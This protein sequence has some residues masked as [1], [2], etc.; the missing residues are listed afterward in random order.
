MLEHFLKYIRN[1]QLFLQTDKVLL[2]VSGGADSRA[3]LHLF[4]TAGIRTAIA[5]CN[6]HL[7]GVESDGDESFVEHLAKEYNLQ[8]FVKHFNTTEYA[9]L[10]KV[11]IQM[12]AREL[13]YNW[14]ENLRRLN[15][16]NYIAT[17]HNADDALETFF[18]NLLRGSGIQGLTGIK[19]RNGYM[20][21]PLLFAYRSEIEEFC[22][23]NRLDFRD[24]SSN[25]S[26]KYLRNRLRHSL[27][28]LL[29]EINP[30]FRPIMTENLTRLS[31][32]E[33]VYSKFISDISKNILESK[34]DGNIYIPIEKLK[35]SPIPKALLFEL[36]KSYGFSSKT[37]I[38]IFE[39][40]DGETGN[41]Y[42]SDEK[43][44]IKD[45]THL[46]ITPLEI[47]KDNKY[48]IDESTEEIMNPI[49]LIIQKIHTR[50][51]NISYDNNI[52]TID[53]DKLSY[54]LLLRHWQKGDY[55]HPLGMEGIKKVSDFF[56][57]SK[58]SIAD[59]ENTWLLTCAGEIVWIVGLRLD[60]RFK[61]TE[62]TR[63]ILQLTLR[64]D[65]E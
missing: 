59:K 28:P 5:H 3:M 32:A 48:Y 13:R 52:C 17:A 41:I 58:M 57:D 56:I 19:P 55:F 37:S 50:D 7:R 35:E 61:I 4:N 2:A 53:A 18:I 43:R 24:D 46:I 44:L 62:K 42:L 54:P 25:T 26:D 15:G 9:E 20:V 31:D 22:K 12:A 51:Y 29:C 14:F 65:K 30:E 21:R 39:N 10:Q 63:N 36:L 60:D 16:F 33:K 47:S 1:N 8:F 38:E 6:F 34:D 23:K 49:H 11:S 40:L 27:I 64:T 45:R